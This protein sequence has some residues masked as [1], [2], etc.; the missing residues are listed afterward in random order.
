MAN[1]THKAVLDEKNGKKSVLRY[2]DYR[3]IIIP[4]LLGETVDKYETC[5]MD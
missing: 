1:M 4:F 2:A 5:H 3:V